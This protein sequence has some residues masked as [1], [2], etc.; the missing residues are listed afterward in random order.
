[1]IGDFTLFLGE[2]AENYGYAEKFG[3]AL[4]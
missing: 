3:C 1:M 2:K 4:S